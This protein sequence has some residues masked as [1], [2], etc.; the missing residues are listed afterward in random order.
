MLRTSTVTAVALVLLAAPA[1]A[2][3]AYGPTGGTDPA[4]AP[5]DPVNHL[6]DGKYAPSVASRPASMCQLYRATGHDTATSPAGPYVGFDNVTIGRTNYNNVPAVTSIIAPLTPQGDSGVLTTRTSH[7]IALPTGTI[8]TTD[9]VLLIPTQTSG[10]YTLISHL[11]ITS[12]ATGQLQLLGTLNLDT[13]SAQGT[14]AGV[15]C[16]LS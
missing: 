12:G 15:I 16:G 2:L 6:R 4:R 10:L 5:A 8:T 3:A 13:L 9:K 11:V 14:F 7:T 1:A